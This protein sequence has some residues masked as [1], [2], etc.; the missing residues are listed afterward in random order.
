V[1]SAAGAASLIA[2][3]RI[4]EKSRRLS[5]PGGRACDF[6]LNWN[7]NSRVMRMCA[8]FLFAECQ[9]C[10]KL[11]KGAGARCFEF[12]TPPRVNTFQ[13]E[14][15][16]TALSAAALLIPR[17]RRF[18]S[19]SL[20]ARLPHT[21]AHVESARSDPRSQNLGVSCGNLTGRC[22]LNSHM[23]NELPA[24][25]PRFLFQLSVN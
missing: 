24:R 16:I 13:V 22:G 18:H 9:F 5:A 8:A 20:R 15:K 4:N 17:Q 23:Q 1:S 14:R 19:L 11:I 21:R 6:D 12:I 2:Q 25:C 10:V 3:S 7:F